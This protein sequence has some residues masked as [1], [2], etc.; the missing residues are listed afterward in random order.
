MACRSPRG[1]PRIC[2]WLA[3]GD[4]RGAMKSTMSDAH[5]AVIFGWGRIVEKRGLGVFGLGSGAGFA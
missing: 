5:G 1:E 2:D 4:F 3:R